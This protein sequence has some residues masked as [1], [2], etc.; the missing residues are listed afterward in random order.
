MEMKNK[1]AVVVGGTGG[2]GAAVCMRLAKEGAKVALTYRTG[3]KDAEQ[4]VQAIEAISED[5]LAEAVDIV[6]YDPVS[7]F[8]KRVVAKWGRLDVLVYAVAAKDTANLFEMTQ[9]QFSTVLDINLKGCFNWIRAAAPIFKEQG[10]GKVVNVASVEAIEGW[11]SVNDAAAQ[12][13]VIG[14]TLAAAREL[15]PHDVNVNAVIPGLVETAAIKA[16]PAEVIERG[17]SRSV[18]GR[19]AKPEEVADVILFLCSARA[20][21]ITGEVIRVD[22]GHHL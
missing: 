8:M 12:S 19:L 11:G 3:R 13:G 2:I 15:G 10:S 7:E 6:A 20:R 21:H 1:V 9:D 22:G 14:L 4:V 16:I 17:L 5:A 18:L